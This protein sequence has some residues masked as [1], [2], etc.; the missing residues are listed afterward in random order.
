[1]AQFNRNDDYPPED[2]PKRRYNTFGD[3]QMSKCDRYNTYIL[4][5]GRISLEEVIVPNPS[6]RPTGTSS[7]QNEYNSDSSSDNEHESSSQSPSQNAFWIQ[8][9]VRGA[10]YGKVYE[11][12][13]LKRLTQNVRTENGNIVSWE[14][15]DG[16]CAIKEYNRQQVR[17]QRGSAE[18][19][20]NEMAA[21]E[22]L[23]NYQQHTLQDIDQNSD[24]GDFKFALDNMYRTN[25]LLSI[26]FFYD[27]THLYTIMPYVDGGELFD[28]L[29]QRQ[30]FSE[31]EARYWMH[32]IMNGLDTLQQAGI[33]HRDM[34]LEN[35]LTDTEGR[36]LIIDMGMCIK[37]PYLDDSQDRVQMYVDHRQRQRCLIRRDRPCGKVRFSFKCFSHIVV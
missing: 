16:K 13:M 21:M 31:P 37:I 30:K 4:W 12:M 24:E 10:I 17:E 11:G 36:A 32:Q 23:W 35:L 8:R 19:P 9:V 33:C 25:V 14:G 22:Y 3:P 5:N 28:V 27:H 26:G 7:T 6:S 29:E 15:V 2:T 20:F 18:N 1:M 34:S